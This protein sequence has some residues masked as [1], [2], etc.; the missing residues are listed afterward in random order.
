[1]LRHIRHWRTAA[2][3]VILF[4]LLSPF[5]AS[6]QSGVSCA[7]FA[8]PD[9]AQHLLDLDDGYAEA[10]DPDGDGVACNEDDRDQQTGEDLSPEDYVNAVW[11]E[12]DL[13]VESVLEFVAVIE[14]SAGDGLS[15][16]ERDR[17]F[18]DSNEIAETW[19]DYPDHAPAFAAPRGYDEVDDLY[20]EWVGALGDLGLAWQAHW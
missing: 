9:A 5:A 15:Q 2:L 4:A 1:M 3:A 8:N 14:T 17:I 11:D 18:E 10:L 20:Q 6:A 13:Q 19:A 7:E 12:V 16:S